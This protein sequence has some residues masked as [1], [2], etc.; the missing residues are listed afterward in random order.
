VTNPSLT[1]ILRLVSAASSPQATKII[2]IDGC[3]GAGKTT[4]AARLAKRLDAQIIHTDD[5]ASWDNTLDWHDR[6]MTQVVTPLSLNTPGRYQRFDWT[7]NALAE[8]HDVPVQPYVIIEGVS[9]IRALFR[10]AYAFTIY[11]E[12]PQD[13]RLER[14]LARDGEQSLSLWQNWQRDEDAYVENESPHT[15]ADIVLDGTAPIP[16]CPHNR[17]K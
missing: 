13:V 14:G 9:S 7:Q 11:V 16:D 4:F 17:H 10:P 8:W 1:D 5:F 6:L 2:G 15:F 3:G 12:A